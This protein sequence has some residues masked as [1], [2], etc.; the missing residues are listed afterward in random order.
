MENL[1]EDIDLK[2][3][4]KDIEIELDYQET[5]VEEEL[6]IDLEGQRR[7]KLLIERDNKK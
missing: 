1:Y 5:C 6:Y 7:R 2:D 3:I 4:L